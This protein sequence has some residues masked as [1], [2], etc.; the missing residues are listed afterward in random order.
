V[1]SAAIVAAIA[2]GLVAGLGNRYTSARAQ[3]HGRIVSLVPALTEMLYAIGAGPQLVAVSSYDTYPPETKTLP[4]VGALID[5]DVERI[6]ALR[7][8]LVMTY[9]S[10]G[11]LESQMSRA[12]IRTFSYRHGGLDA[13][14]QTMRELGRVTGHVME[15]ERVEA[16]IRQELDG[17]RMS[18]RGRARPRTL[19]VF[20]RQPESLQQIY[21]SGGIGFLHEVLVAAGGTNAFA[22][23][24]RESVQPSQET[25][26]A[27][28][29][30][31][32]VEIRAVGM[33]DSR[34]E[35]ERR[36]WSPLASIPAVRQRRIYFLT[37]DYF[38]IPG[39]RVGR[40]AEAIARALHP[41][42]F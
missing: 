21:V 25:L 13:I 34:T 20:G 4:R 42:A 36:A 39:P 22:D 29:P 37:G 3:V 33:D 38:M 9:G 12:G 19:L 40:T 15:A 16:A 28:S 35:R 41:D 18:V 5:P 10:Q 11:S 2:I 6:L 31:V 7:P 14:F 17:V 23:V 27:R 1:R 8:D 32:I 24:T 30:E 26:L